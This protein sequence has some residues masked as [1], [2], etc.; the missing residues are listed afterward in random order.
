MRYRILK[1]RIFKV[2]YNQRSMM[3]VSDG[4]TDCSMND[5]EAGAHWNT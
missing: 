2:L 1:R 5:I 3:L 4:E